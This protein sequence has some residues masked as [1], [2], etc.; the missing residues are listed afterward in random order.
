MKINPKQYIL[1]QIQETILAEGKNWP[2]LDILQ[3]C[4]AKATVSEYN[5]VEYKT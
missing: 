4:V 1:C 2:S 5:Y 3:P